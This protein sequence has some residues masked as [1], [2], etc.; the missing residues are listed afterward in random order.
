MDIGVHELRNSLRQSV[1][2][3]RAWNFIVSKAFYFNVKHLP[4]LKRFFFSFFLFFFYENVLRKDIHQ[5]VVTLVP[6]LLFPY[7]IKHLVLLTTQRGREK[8]AVCCTPTFIMWS[9]TGPDCLYI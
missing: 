6:I 7:L 9:G 4:L 5:V 1:F 3:I 2:P 8:E